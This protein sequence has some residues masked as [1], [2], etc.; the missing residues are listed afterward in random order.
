M[1]VPLSYV[2]CATPELQTHANIPDHF[3]YYFQ[4]KHNKEDTVLILCCS[5]L[6]Y[7]LP[8]VPHFTGMCMQTNSSTQYFKC[9]IC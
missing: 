2:S 8:S 7:P 3:Q 5:C 6:Q 4:G 9:L 1:L